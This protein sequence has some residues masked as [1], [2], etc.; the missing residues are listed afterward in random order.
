MGS[1]ILYL[2]AFLI[3]FSLFAYFQGNVY[4]DVKS[5]K[6][7]LVVKLY[8]MITILGGYLSPCP[9][10]VAWHISKKKAILLSYRQIDDGRRRASK[11]ND[12]K[13][14]SLSVVLELGP[15]YLLPTSLIMNIIQFWAFASE[16]RNAFTYRI[17]PKSGDTFRFFGRFWLRFRIWQYLLNAIKKL[18]IR[19]GTESVER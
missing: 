8:G 18:L 15:E 5:G 2:T 16:N 1:F 12:V 19:R 9:G 10:G 4:F 3:A 7:G 13:F 6:V 11:G 17:I 14:H